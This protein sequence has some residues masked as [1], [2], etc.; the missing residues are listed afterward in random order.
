M[1]QVIMVVL[2][3]KLIG[4]IPQKSRKVTA[5]GAVA[6]LN[7]FLLYTDLSVK[8]ASVSANESFQFTLKNFPYITVFDADTINSLYE[9]H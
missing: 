1:F 5:F 6:V 9:P 8:T 7:L 2:V 3:P 4:A